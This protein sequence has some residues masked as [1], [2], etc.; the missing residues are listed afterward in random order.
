[1]TKKTVLITGGVRGI[2]EAIAKSFIDNGYT[3]I[4]TSYKKRTEE[5]RISGQIVKN[6]AFDVGNFEEVQ[7]GVENILKD[8]STI[9]V[10]IHNAGI[11]R[12]ASLLKMT[13]EMWKDVIQTNLFSCFNLT[14]SILPTMISNKYGR[15]IFLSSVNAFKGQFGQ[16]NYC[17]SK[18][19]MIGFMKALSLEVIQKGITVNAIAPGYIDTE[20]V[21][22]V[23]EKIL[24]QIISTIPIK[25][26]GQTEEVANTALFIASKEASYTTGQTFHINGGLYLA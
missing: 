3:V 14:Q 2:G 17:A 11:T 20:M 4:T 10:L 9:D 5:V 23:P 25:R 26:L 8:F 24:E 19:G 22:A 18:A 21:R 6:Y 13:K 16:T 12:D 15:I 1:M 7:E